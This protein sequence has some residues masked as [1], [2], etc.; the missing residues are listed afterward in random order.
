[1]TEDDFIGLR[2]GDMGKAERRAGCETGSD[3]ER[4]ATIDGRGQQALAFLHD[5]PPTYA[6]FDCSATLP[7]A[8]KARFRFIQCRKAEW[9]AGNMK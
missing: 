9:Q 7:V 4:V 6:F 1:M 5:N 8:A 3:L 2:S